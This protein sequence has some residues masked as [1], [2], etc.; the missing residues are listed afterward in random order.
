MA[1]MHVLSI[2]V[3]GAINQDQLLEALQQEEAFFKNE[4]AAQNI[5]L[6]QV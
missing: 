3:S 4:L 5:T 2:T 1:Y 6:E